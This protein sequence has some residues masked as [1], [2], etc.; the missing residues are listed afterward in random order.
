VTRSVTFLLPDATAEL[1]RDLA[2]RDGVDPERR[3]YDSLRLWVFSPPPNLPPGFGSSRKHLVSLLLQQGFIDLPDGTRLREAAVSEA[4]G[5]YR[6][7]LSEPE[8]L[9]QSTPGGPER[10]TLKVGERLADVLPY[11][12]AITDLTDLRGVPRTKRTWYDVR[13]FVRAVVIT[14]AARKDADTDLRDSEEEMSGLYPASVKSAAAA[15][16]AGPRTV[17]P[18]ALPRA[19]ESADAG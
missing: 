10:M 14:E 8:P 18:A 7:E 17:V 19:R 6:D 16:E 3:A 1:L 12:L 13:S 5:K 15:R 4:A 11:A 9:P 2:D